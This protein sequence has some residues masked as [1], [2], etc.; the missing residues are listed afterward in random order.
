MKRAVFLLALFFVCTSFVFADIKIEEEHRVENMKPGYCCWA[1]IE[2]L[3][4]KHGIKQL[5]GL[6]KRRSQESDF[7][8]WDS[9][10]Q[11]WKQLPYVWVEY[12]NGSKRKV[13]RSPGD[14]Q[15]MINRL[16]KLN[17]AFK[18][19]SSGNYDL[20]LIKYAMK[21]KL[22]CM[23]V[24]DWGGWK[25]GYR[26][27]AYTHAVVLTKFNDKEVMFIDPNKTHKYWWV[28]RAWFNRYWMG[29]TLVIVPN[30]TKVIKTYKGVDIKN[31][32]YG[33][34]R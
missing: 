1:S 17:V 12:P 19:Q 8:Q 4:R 2:T 20:G 18:F 27:G 14:D 15:A 31:V 24:F 32:R 25:R 16:R 33:R 30:E 6:V 29:E 21:N 22:G 26:R 28:S 23:V 9:K 10:T 5:H 3:G 11:A 7:K 34:L 13:H